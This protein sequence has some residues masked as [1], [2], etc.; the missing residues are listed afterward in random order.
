[1]QYQIATRAQIL[2]LLAAGFEY[3]QI[4]DHTGVSPDTQ[5]TWWAKALKRGFD[6]TARP[7]LI[8]DRFVED[9]KRSGRPRRK[10]EDKDNDKDKG[11]DS[12]K[13]NEKGNEGEVLE[14]A[15]SDRNDPD[16]AV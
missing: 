11:K 7:V 13:D 3:R 1:M 8:V 5:K 12:E 15:Q 6:P 4:F 16:D 10:D 14:T 2:G 9:G